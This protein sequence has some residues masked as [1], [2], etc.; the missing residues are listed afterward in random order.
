MELLQ[1]YLVP[2]LVSNTTAVLILGLAF[3]RPRIARLLFVL[4]FAWACWINLT[5]VRISPESYVEYA[6]FTPIALLSDFIE[7]WFSEHALT[8]VSAIAIGQGI[9]ALGFL[10][11]GFWVRFACI[12]AIIFQLAILPL[13]IGSGFPATLIGALAAFVILKKD[14]MDFLWRSEKTNSNNRSD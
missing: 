11:N 10:L 7:G 14:R 3:W 6:E 8:M 2:W 1:E 12:G 5:T 9:I 13:G 4:L